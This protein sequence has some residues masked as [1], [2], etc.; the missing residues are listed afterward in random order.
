MTRFATSYLTLGCLNDNR[1]ALIRMFSS[2]EW[3]SSRF[4]RTKKGKLIEDVVM[5]KRFWKN[6][7]VCL[8]GAYPLIKVL[9]FVNSDKK[10]MAFIYEE[11]HQAK[12]KIQSVFNGVKKSYM[13]LWDVIDERWDK[14]LCRPLHVAGYYLNPQLHYSPGFKANFEVQRGFYDCLQRIVGSLEETTKIDTQ[15]ENF[16][17]QSKFFGSG[18]A[19]MAIDT[20]TPLQW[21]DSYAFEHPEL[22]QFAIRVLSLTC[23]SFGGERNR[24]A[25]EMVHTKRR[26]RLKQKTMNDVV[27]VMANSKLAKMK[28]DAGKTI[29]YGID[30]L[31]SDDDWIVDHDESSSNDEDLDLDNLDLDTPNQEDLVQVGEHATGGVGAPLDDM[32][33]PN[34]DDEPDG[35]ED[36]M[37]HF[38]DEDYMKNVFNDRDLNDLLD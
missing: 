33:I 9:H 4:A 5:D 12:E 18:F 7:I 13:P 31:S 15:L 29:E 25:F 30:D 26:N 19:K 8:K 1:G 28:D 10:P 23:S 24:N 21:W 3:K 20:K 32:E 37:H 2:N 14:Q 27:F 38:G 22:E 34:F 35:E 16:K 11:M 6:I 17:S 36:A